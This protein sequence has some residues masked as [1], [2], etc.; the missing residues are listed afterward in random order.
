MLYGTGIAVFK[1]A[2]FLT[3]SQIVD[4]KISYSPHGGY[5]FL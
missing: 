1:V 3:A 4:R 5:S 2:A